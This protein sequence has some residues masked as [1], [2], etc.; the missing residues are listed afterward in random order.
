MAIGYMAILTTCKECGRHYKA[1]SRLAECPH[2]FKDAW[3][4][5]L[6]ENTIKSSKKGA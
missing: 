1:G 3:L 5:R 6:V 2:H 4:R